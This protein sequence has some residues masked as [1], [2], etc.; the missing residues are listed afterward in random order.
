MA[1][2]AAISARSQNAS[3]NRLEA[4]IASERKPRAANPLN[5]PTAMAA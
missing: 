2:E 4:E 3:L 5:P 1:I